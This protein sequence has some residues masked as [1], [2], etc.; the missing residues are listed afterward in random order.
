MQLKN[1][2]IQV[3]SIT[4]LRRKMIVSFTG[5]LITVLLIIH[6]TYYYQSYVTFEKNLTDSV[7][8]S[9]KMGLTNIDFYFE[10]VNN[11]STSI[12]SEAY[13]QEILKYDFEK[14]DLDFRIRIRTLEKIISQYTSARPYIQ[15]VY[16]INKNKEI[17]DNS[18]N[19]MTITDDLYNDGSSAPRF[20]SIHKASYISS[21]PA[22]VSFIKNI[23]SIQYPKNKIGTLIADF[24]ANVI[25]KVVKDFQ[26][27]MKG[28]IFLVDSSGGLIYKSGEADIS[29]SEFLDQI[30]KLSDGN[31]MISIG[32][33]KY[34][35]MAEASSNT[36]WRL[37][38]LIPYRSFSN[39]IIMQTNVVLF[40]IIIGVL[41]SFIISRRIIYSMYRPIDLIITSMKK[42]EKGNLDSTVA[43]QNKN[44][45]LQL[46]E[47][48]NSMLSKIT[49]LIEQVKNKEQSKR[50]AE[51]YALQAQINPHFLFNT[52]NSIRYLSKV[53]NA[54]EIR[55]ITAALISLSS[56]S[57]DSEKF[58]TISHE[59]E[60]VNDYL[61]IQKIRYGDILD[62]SCTLDEAAGEYL[63]PRFSIQPIVENALFHGI[64]PKGEGKILVSINME[65]NEIIISVTDNGIGIPELKLQEINNQL[66]SDEYKD[67]S[68]DVSEIRKLKNIGLEN[69]N[70]RI[71]MNFSGAYGLS[72]YRNAKSGLCVKII[73]PAIKEASAY[74]KSSDRG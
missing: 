7:H 69:I 74:E 2:L 45:L 25:E 4:S 21:H 17:L 51:L 29:E 34:I 46:V 65:N 44:E 16:L 52:L 19:G 27:P 14:Q 5:L 12:L 36:D 38:S 28:N 47:G 37:I 57:L 22:V 32:P 63:I 39:S 20:S 3:F 23:Y 72:L 42:V 10:D 13:V 30:K 67:Y 26:L 1:K 8:Q 56:A 73:I 15:K 31:K 53:Y 50:Q 60:L 64:L 66:L 41:A 43:Y 11:L 24:N 59:L 6:I 54:P 62:Y 70:Y 48:Y 9:L 18:L 55:D 35:C 58:I 49:T 40:F 68:N 33:T 71:K 61:Y